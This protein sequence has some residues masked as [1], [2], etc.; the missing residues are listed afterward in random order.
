MPKTK[1][2]DPELL[3]ETPTPTTYSLT[4]YDSDGG[5]AQDIDLSREEFIAL[6]NHVAGM[7]GHSQ[8][9]DESQA[10]VSQREIGVLL[11]LDSMMTTLAANL[12]RRLFMGAAVEPGELQIE[13]DTED[14]NAVKFSEGFPALESFRATG[15]RLA[16][17]VSVDRVKTA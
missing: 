12:R 6:K 5:A 16:C 3:R 14:E 8:Q 13:A 17:G 1:T 15:I 9:I 7:R 4:M 2:A 10:Y 11:D